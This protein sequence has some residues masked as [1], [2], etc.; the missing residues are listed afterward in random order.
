MGPEDPLPCGRGNCQEFTRGF[1]IL[2]NAF[3]HPLSKT[4]TSQ[5]KKRQ[6]GRAGVM[7]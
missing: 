4:G 5:L 3:Y 6:L 7:H 1:K 2:K